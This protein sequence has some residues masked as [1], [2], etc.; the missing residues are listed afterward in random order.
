MSCAIFVVDVSGN[1]YKMRVS[2]SVGEGFA[3]FKPWQECCALLDA[4]LYHGDFLLCLTQV[5]M[6]RVSNYLPAKARP[7]R[8]EDLGKAMVVNA[9]LQGSGVE[10]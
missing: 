4:D 3:A 8:V 10:V 1:K 6:P 2:D 5:W 7:I 9:E